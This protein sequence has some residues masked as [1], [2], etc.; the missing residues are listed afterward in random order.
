MIDPFP[1]QPSQAGAEACAGSYLTNQARGSWRAHPTTP[2]VPRLGSATCTDHR[3]PQPAPRTRMKARDRRRASASMRA[4]LTRSPVRPRLPSRPLY[5]PWRRRPLPP[6][7]SYRA[8]AHLR[9]PP[10][11]SGQVC[12][13]HS[14]TDA[15]P[16]LG[17]I[18]SVPTRTTRAGDPA[19]CAGCPTPAKAP[20]RPFAALRATT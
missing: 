13:S 15:F 9:A 14:R 10:V 5:R 11:R 4:A 8:T 1:G 17:G 20:L 2:T 6:D 12:H 16:P 19:R 3:S 18:R 7:P